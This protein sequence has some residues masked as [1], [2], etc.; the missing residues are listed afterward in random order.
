MGKVQRDSTSEEK[1]LEAAR[2]V[3]IAKGMA[4][5]R[6]QDI[7][8]EAGINKALLHYYFRS[9]E[10]LFE[11]IFKEL[12]FQF[13]PRV[14]FI[15]ESD[16]PLFSKIEMFCSEYISK[17]IEN[18]FIPLF[19]VNEMNKQPETFLKKMWGT[20]KPLVS[21]FIEQVEQEVKKGRI[22]K[23]Q[24][25]HLLLN[26][27]S[28]CIFPFVGK[29]LCQLVMGINEPTYRQLLEERKKL[30]PQFIIQSISK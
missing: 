27:V 6:M 18:P 20:K 22:R 19:I 17:M 14:N 11:T 29:P 12:S 10:K 24:P 4:G 21:K 13:L 2:K 15:F 9:K 23:I 25:T 5:A 26:M 30:V 28:M 16:L 7:A 8:D 1:I 3:F